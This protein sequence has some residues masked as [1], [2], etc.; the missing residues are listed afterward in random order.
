MPPPRKEPYIYR[1]PGRKGLFAWLS[2]DV[3]HIPLH[4]DD[5]EE[6]LRKLSG[7]L[8]SRRLQA[9]QRGATA[10][11]S[12]FE[13]CADRSRTNHTRKTAYEVALN[14]RRLTTWCEEHGVAT[15]EGITSAHVEHYKTARLRPA[16][17]DCEHCREEG[18]VGVS[19]ARVNRELDTWKKA[20]R[21][22]LEGGT[23]LAVGLEAF[24]HVREPRPAPHGR[25]LRKAELQAFLRAAPDG[26]R[27]LFRLI[28]G[29]ALRDEETVHLDSDDVQLHA[30]VVNPKP[31]GWCPCCPKGWTSKSYRHRTIPASPATVKAARAF[32]AVRDSLRLHDKKRTWLVLREACS[33]AKV[34][35]FSLHD[36]RRAC[37]SH[38]L[39]AGVLPLTIS[40]WLG[41]AD[42]VTTLRYLRIVEE[43]PA[44]LRLPW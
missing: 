41:H 7:L 35:P 16:E 20:M 13:E 39:A 26:Y 14:L 1:R 18:R 44:K 15:V 6:G 25:G 31:P 38:W 36:L 3:K 2:R 4:T 42:L 43:V 37:A 24:A 30:I 23:A 32:L 29:A 11:S 17:I 10:L 21:V 40:K 33:A 22:A 5:N 28:L 19:A 27:D 8:E 12:A 9:P 34:E